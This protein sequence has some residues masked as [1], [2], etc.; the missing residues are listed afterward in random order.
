ML[1]LQLAAL[2]YRLIAVGILSDISWCYFG[3][4]VYAKFVSSINYQKERDFYSINRVVVIVYFILVN[5]A[6]R[7]WKGNVIQIPSSCID[8]MFQALH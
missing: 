5:V 6:S 3:P 4:R 8:G 2:P 1:V 7:Y